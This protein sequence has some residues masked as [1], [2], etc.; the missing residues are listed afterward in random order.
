MSYIGEFKEDGYRICVLDYESEEFTSFVGFD[1]TGDYYKSARLTP[2]P[3]FSGHLPA[4]FLL[5]LQLD[6]MYRIKEEQA[7]GHT[8]KRVPILGHMRR[9][10]PC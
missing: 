9:E 10:G 4:G 3:V 1:F 2:L 6:R 7:C 5:Y 8:Y